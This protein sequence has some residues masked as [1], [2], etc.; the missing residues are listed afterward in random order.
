MYIYTGVGDGTFRGP[1]PL[2]M[3]RGGRAGG[4]V[5]AVAYS[6]L[7]SVCNVLVDLDGDGDLDLVSA[8]NNPVLHHDRFS[9]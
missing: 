2:T 4:T 9:L 3:T 6:V 1:T 8:G 5:P 7:N